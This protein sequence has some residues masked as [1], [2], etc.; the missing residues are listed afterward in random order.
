MCA[1][2]SPSVLLPSPSFSS[3]CL[4]QPLLWGEAPSA[5]GP[6]PRLPSTLRSPPATRP[7]CSCMNDTT[8]VFDNL[9]AQFLSSYEG[10]RA[11][12][13][14]AHHLPSATPLRLLPADCECPRS[15]RLTACLAPLRAR[16]PCCA[17]FV[18]IYWLQAAD[19]L[20]QL[21]RFMG[22]PAVL[23]P[24]AVAACQHTGQHGHAWLG[25][26]CCRA[27][28]QAPPPSPTTSLA[29]PPPP[30]SPRRLGA[31]AAG[32]VARHDAPA[33]G[34]DEKPGARLG[35]HPRGAGLRQRRRPARLPGRRRGAAAGGVMALC[36][37]RSAPLLL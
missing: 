29:R 10:S 28:A 23:L 8:S 13:P 6:A 31:G 11:P 34:V 21:Q 22:A 37:P 2:P 32:C 4:K 5:P 1:L 27:A 9:K 26:L 3:C 25:R 24:S 30:P 12:F 16:I 33:A 14:G 36:G 15:S 18:H 20:Q 19:N 17:V 7:Q 35:A